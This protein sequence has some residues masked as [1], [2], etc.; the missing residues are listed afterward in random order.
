MRFLRALSVGAWLLGL[1]A[2][3]CGDNSAGTG[4]TG[5]DT[6]APPLDCDPLAPDYCGFPYP[7]DY[8]TV[9]SDSTP[10]GRQ[11]SLPEVIMPAN[12]SGARS[13]PDAF[14]EA[15]GFSPGIAGMTL[16]PGA[17]LQGLNPST[18][19]ES[20]LSDDARTVVL[21]AATGERV[22]HWVELD[23]YVIEAAARVDASAPR[24]E[25]DIG[26]DR[27]ELENER[28]LMIRPAV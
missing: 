16:M 20:S 21:N 13:T 8:W 26:R 17:T 19:I 11:L 12:T 3:G 2:M 9:E 1:L 22:A 28:T 7:N 4:G 5:G 25:F 18:D 10:T 14:N 24:P 6:P 23:E 15:D 27:D